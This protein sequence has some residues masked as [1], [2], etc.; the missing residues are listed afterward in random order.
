M[1]S[2]TLIRFHTKGLW[3][4]G[5]AISPDLTQST[6]FPPCTGLLDISAFISPSLLY[7]PTDFQNCFH[8]YLNYA[9]G[10]PI[11]LHSAN[12]NSSRDL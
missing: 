7:T 8:F 2:R 6:T 1:K 5:I 4:S 10:N 3:I 12:I 11:P 9:V